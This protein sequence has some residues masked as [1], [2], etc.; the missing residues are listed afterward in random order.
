MAE[1]NWSNPE[2][3][4]PLVNTSSDEIY[5]FIDGLGDLYFSSNGKVGFGDFD[6]WNVH[7]DSL[8]QSEPKLLGARINS[9]FD[10][11][12]YIIHSK[13]GLGTLFS[14]RDAKDNYAPIRF[15]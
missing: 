1:P 10:D 13:S 7:L 14:N 6:V 5:P 8:G 3:L 15:Q 2:N 9:S 12:G 11:F 4:G